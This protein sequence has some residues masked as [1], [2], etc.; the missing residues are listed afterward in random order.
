MVDKSKLSIKDLARIANV[1]HSTVSR[2]L[3]SS[4]LVNAKTAE[5]IRQ[6]AVEQG[7]RPSAVARSLATRRTRTVGVVVT[8]IAD[9][10][11]AEVFNGIEEEALAHDYSLLLANCHGDPDHE[12]KVVQLFDEHRVDGIMVTSSRVGALYG[13]VLERMKIPIVLL[14]SQHPS[15]FAHSVMI[16]NLE[17][18]RNA[19]RH[20]IDLGHRRIA[21]IGDRFGYGSD[22]ERFSG[23]RSALDGAD[24]PFQPG[25]VAHGDGKAEGAF[26]AVEM[27]VTAPQPPTAIFCYND[28]TALG[29]LKALRE[30]KLRV[31]EDIS[32]VG[33]DDLPLAEY[34]E[35][36]ITTV[37]QPKLEMGKLAMRVLLKLIDGSDAENDIR[38]GG[39]LIVRRS[40]A[41]PKEGEQ[42]NYSHTPKADPNP[43]A[44][45]LSSS[46]SASPR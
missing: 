17:A 3:Q 14:N 38:V 45:D 36:P 28:M 42:C 19:V 12:V 4:P 26:A 5:K 13:P 33:F 39:E 24:I 11:A 6:I 46:P 15:R 32:V 40:T 29:V 25:L 22:S 44:T 23:Y 20:L 2:A 21:Y 7:F 8:T 27:L 43:K 16:E 31:P 41:P 34:M 10:F 30:R 35:P 18:S 9:P 1:S 37:R